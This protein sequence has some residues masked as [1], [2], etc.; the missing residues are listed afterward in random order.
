EIVLNVEEF[1]ESVLNVKS[2]KEEAKSAL[3]NSLQK[4]RREDGHE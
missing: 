2:V 3:F 1:A 4:S